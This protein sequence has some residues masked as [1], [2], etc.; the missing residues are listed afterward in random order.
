MCP[1]NADFLKS[2]GND[3]GKQTDP[4]S[5]LYNGPYLL[6]SITAKSSM[7][8]EKNPNYW[9]ADNVHIDDV[10]L[11]YFDGSDQDSLFNNF[12][13]GSYTSAALYPSSQAI[14]QQK[15]NIVIIL[16]MLNKMLQHL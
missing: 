12:D 9:D 5:L 15:R 6:K 1:V 7:E 11:T 3:F 8:F 2:K 16:F 14:K 13:E 4:E 10:K